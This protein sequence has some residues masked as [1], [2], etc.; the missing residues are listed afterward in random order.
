MSHASMNASA[1]LA[2]ATARRTEDA[3][4]LL[5]ILVN[6]DTGSRS[7]DGLSTAGNWIQEQLEGL[8][9]LVER[10]EHADAG[11]TLVGRRSGSGRLRLLFLAHYDTVFDPGEPARRPFRVEAGRAYGPGVADMKGGIVTLWEALRVLNGEGWDNF[12]T[13]TVI[14]NAD[15]EV[16]SLASRGIIE[17]EGR[18]CDLC[19]VHE[20][21]RLDGS[22][23]TARKGV[24]RYV[25]TVH[26]RAAHAG[27]N[28]QDG[29]SAVVALA[30]K[31]LE[32]HALNDPA[33]GVSA[34]TIVTAGGTRS[35]VVPDLAAAEIDLR[36]PTVALGAEA[37]ARLEEITQ[38]QH[39]PGTHAT[40]SG[41]VNRPPFEAG[42][43]SLALFELARE[44]AAV[45]GFPLTAATTGGGSDGNF[46]APLGVPVLDGMGA[47]GG[48]YHGPDEYLELATLPRRAAL[49]ALLV[50]EVCR[51]GAA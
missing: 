40:L 16:G 14:H 49:T 12:A 18:N 30:R 9:L 24:G 38:A 45:L 7:L 4:R 42:P 46:I 43:G 32:I 15:E 17:A 29:A 35:N 50:W 51:R 10:H 13:L 11:P 20:P 26:G 39:L 8:G 5:E 41:E 28:P 22:V 19:L 1:R 36:L 6:M 48:G 3:L 37:I 44:A 23:V 27:V 34:N 21:G 2:A 31:I 47:V 33:R 25:L